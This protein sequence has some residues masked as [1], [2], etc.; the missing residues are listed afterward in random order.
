MKSKID[1][2]SELKIEEDF[3]D[4]AADVKLA[5]MIGETLGSGEA[6]QPRATQKRRHNSNH[7]QRANDHIKKV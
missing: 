7:E 4:E 2:E 3:V 1:S 6:K 5:E